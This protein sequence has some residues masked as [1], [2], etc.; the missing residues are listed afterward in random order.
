[1]QNISKFF[2]NSKVKVLGGD[3]TEGEWEFSRGV[4]WGAF[5]HIELQGAIKKVQPQT[6]ESV[7][8]VSETLGWGLAGLVALGPVGALA[9]AVMGGNRK[10][11]C[12]LIELNDDRKFLAVMD[13]KIYQ[14][15]LALSL[16]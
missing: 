3:L 16:K 11:V 15:I 7:K 1:M 8:K 13:S 2:D 12:A 6:E 4:L 10:S 5:E 14:E 9:G